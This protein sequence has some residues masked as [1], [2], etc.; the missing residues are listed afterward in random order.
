MILRKKS[1]IFIDSDKITYD[2]DKV[3]RDVE[4]LNRFMEAYS[5]VDGEFKQERYLD[6]FNGVAIWLFIFYIFLF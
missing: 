4:I 3:K 6:C 1:F 2:M 5:F